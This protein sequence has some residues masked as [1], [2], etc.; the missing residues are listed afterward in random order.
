MTARPR[1]LTV[2]EFAALPENGDVT[3]ELQ[4][5]ALVISPSPFDAPAATGV[6][7]AEEPFPVRLELDPLLGPPA[8]R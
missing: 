7:T 2:A 3:C 6:F 8:Q 1:L 5:G 4:E